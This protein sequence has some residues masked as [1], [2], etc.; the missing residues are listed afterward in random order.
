MLVKEYHSFHP[1]FFRERDTKKPEYISVPKF[2]YLSLFLESYSRFW[3][4]ISDVAD[5][6]L[7]LF[8]NSGL[9]QLKILSRKI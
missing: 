6:R 8:L 9:N 4:A 7:Y 2:F 3:K 1:V 5:S